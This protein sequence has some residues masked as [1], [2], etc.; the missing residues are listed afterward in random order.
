MIAKLCG[1]LVGI[2]LTWTSAATGLFLVHE[3][4]SCTLRVPYYKV[5]VRRVQSVENALS[6]YWIRRH[7]CPATRDDLV[8][9][10]YIDRES[11]VDPWGIRIAYRCS[12]EEVVAMSAGPDR[13]FD[14]ADDIK[15]SEANDRT[16]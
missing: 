6:W 13:A 11:L 2:A 4:G 14:T 15:S 5:A 3:L 1:I 16:R 9:N 12:D 7:E 10:G 8:T